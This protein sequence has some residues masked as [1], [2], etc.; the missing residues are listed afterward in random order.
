[1]DSPLERLLPLS[2]LEVLFAEE[3]LMVLFTDLE[4]VL[5]SDPSKLLERLIFA[6]PDV[7]LLD[8]PLERLL[9]LSLL[10]MLFAEEVLMVL[11]TDLEPVLWSD[12]S[13]LLERP[14]FADPAFR[15]LDSPLEQLLP[16]SLLKLLYAEEVLMVLFTDLEP[17][18]WFDP[19]KP[20]FS[21]LE[22]P[23]FAD[24]TFWLL[25]SPL[26]CLFG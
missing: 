24:P 7:R 18:L 23:S 14:F 3:V 13:K 12:P 20:S 21:C 19:S 16:L 9:P 4:P 22:R 5:W 26:V 11:F 10:E 15:L 25:D 17:V 2:L 6:D 1:L 8:S